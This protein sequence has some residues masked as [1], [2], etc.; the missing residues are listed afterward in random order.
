MC[1]VCV[2][3]PPG[4]GIQEGLVDLD[5]DLTHSIRDGGGARGLCLERETRNKV[6][7]AT[8]WRSPLLCPP[9][10]LLLSPLFKS[11]LEEVKI[12][13]HSSGGKAKNEKNIL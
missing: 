4:P 5:L 7:D 8:L 3:H 1:V 11:E 6:S 9:L 12:R 2:S 10:S 13:K